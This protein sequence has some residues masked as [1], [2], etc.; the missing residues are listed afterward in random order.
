MPAQVVEAIILQVEPYGESDLLVE[1]FSRFQGRLK[2][3]AKGAKKSKKR[4][5]HCFE[6]LN[7]VRLWLFE[8][9]NYSLVRID[10]GEVIESFS[11]IR[12]HLRKWGL[13]LYCVEMIPS[14]FA[15]ADPH[16]EVFE[17]LKQALGRL[18]EK[19]PEQEIFE[20]LRLR[21]LRAA[22]Y[23]LHLDGCTGC[24]KKVE[25]L[26]EP[27]FSFTGGGLYCPACLQGESGQCLSRGTVETL[28]RMM[29]M[30]VPQVFRIRFTR[31]VAEEI[32][33]LMH[34]FTEQMLGKTLK[35]ARYLKQM[36]EPYG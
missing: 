32:E 24:G 35:A 4:F 5:V 31:E 15:V 22:G 18:A 26:R 20:I 29:T 25:E 3:M 1:F 9:P 12:R 36:Q 11:E 10:Q 2:G 30:A 13:A 21:L 33:P 34:T 17:L 7:R 27:V 14:L 6:P 23:G 8:K 19:K 16:P 28:R